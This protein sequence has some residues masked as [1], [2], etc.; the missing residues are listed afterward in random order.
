[1]ADKATGGTA[2]DMAS[3]VVPRNKPASWATLAGM[4]RVNVDYGNTALNGLVLDESTKLP[5]SPRVLDETLLFGNASSLT[6]IPQVLHNNYVSRIARIN[7]SLSNPVVEV[8]H[9]AA[10]LPRQPSQEALGPLRAL[11]LERLPQPGVSLPNMRGLPSRKFQ[12]T[13]GGSKVIYAAINA[14]N[15]AVPLREGHFPIDD[16]VD[17]ELFRAPVVAE[18]G[19]GGFLSCQEPALEVADGKGK[20]DSAAYRGNGNFPTFFI[21]GEG[22][23]VKAHARWFELPG[24][25]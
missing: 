5:E 15:V 13:G 22:A 19:G 7:D 3:A 18:G 10:L 12:A 2:E 16:D 4:T 8:G 21:E 25:G 23:L 20:L 6:D 17:V 9:P 1:M 11:G 24:L 14:D